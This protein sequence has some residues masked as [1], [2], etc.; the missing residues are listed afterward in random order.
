MSSDYDD[1]PAIGIEEAWLDE[2]NER[3]LRSREEADFAQGDPADADEPDP[4]NNE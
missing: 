4:E 2:Q 3:A 1:L